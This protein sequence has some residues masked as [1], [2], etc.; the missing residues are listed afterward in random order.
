MGNDD[1]LTNEDLERLVNSTS[2]I[3]LELEPEDFE[4]VRVATKTNGAIRIDAVRPW[5]EFLFRGSEVLIQFNDRC[6]FWSV[7]EV[8]IGSVTLRWVRETED[9]LRP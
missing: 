5:P 3:V 4:K 8:S 9:L 1:C 7:D 2:G 6:D